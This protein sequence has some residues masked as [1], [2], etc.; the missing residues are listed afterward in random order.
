MTKVSELSGPLLDYWVA[1]ANGV[2]GVK[3]WN[4]GAFSLFQWD[5]TKHDQFEFCYSTDWS[6][7]G[8]IIEREHIATRYSPSLFGIEAFWEAEIAPSPFQRVD[9]F[10][11][12]E[13]VNAYATGP[14]LLVAAMRA[15]V[16]S[17]FGD[18]VEEVPVHD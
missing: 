9:Y 15:Y 4:D 14:T 13:P 12:P 3:L 5:D 6:Q 10:P 16:A 1:Q 18:E 17:K 7:G 11:S 2:T 8:P